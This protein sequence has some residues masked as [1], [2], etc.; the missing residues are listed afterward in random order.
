MHAVSIPRSA[1]HLN[2]ARV[3]VKASFPSNMSS[4]SARTLATVSNRNPVKVAFFG[5]G[6]INFGSPEGPWNHSAR[7]EKVLGK[8][9][10]VTALIDPVA[11]NRAHVLQDKAQSPAASSYAATAQYDTLEQYLSDLRP[12]LRP[13]AAI[14]GVPP[15]F[16]GSLKKGANLELQ[17]AKAMPNAFLFVEKP[18]SKTSTEEVHLVG[19]RL[20]ELESPVGVGYFMRYLQV[21][22]RVKQ[23]I[24]ENDLNVMATTARF[25]S[26]YTTIE[27]EHWWKKSISG[28]PIVEQ[29]T[30]LCDLSR[31]FGGDV[32]IESVF[33]H[34]VE[35]WEKPGKLSKLPINEKVIPKDDRIP[36]LTAAVWKYKSGAVGSITHGISLHGSHYSAEIEVMADGWLFRVVDPYNHPKLYVRSPTCEEEQEQQFP[37]D[38]P[39]LTQMAALV[40]TVRAKQK[41]V[42]NSE[43]LKAGGILSNWEDGA[44][45]YELTWAIGIASALREKHDGLMEA[46][47]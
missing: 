3:A 13:D 31:F 22:G 2:K 12:E 21:V 37:E 43:L 30:H 14:I 4:Q 9:L 24:K 38:D 25:F 15:A 44:K 6:G 16:H 26:C 8:D 17:L 35:Y 29:G 18:I 47:V 10:I 39:Y 46:V 45:S 42:R 40:E 41:G 33:A 27:K 20:A 5:A 32:D 23:L 34:A 28:P 36:R 7:L 19:K 1:L 11:E